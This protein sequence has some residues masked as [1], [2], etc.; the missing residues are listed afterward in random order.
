MDSRDFQRYLRND[1]VIQ[2]SNEIDLHY[3]YIF[4]CPIFLYSY[5]FSK[6]YTCTEDFRHLKA[7]SYFFTAQS[8]RIAKHSK[9][10]ANFFDTFFSFHLTECFTFHIYYCYNSVKFTLTKPLYSLAIKKTFFY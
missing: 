7:D 1:L 9:T 4:C 10:Y 2:T 5:L 6:C 3:V 8:G